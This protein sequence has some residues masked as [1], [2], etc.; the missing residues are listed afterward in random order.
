MS[1]NNLLNSNQ[2]NSETKE[3]AKLLSPKK[4]V[5]FQVLFGEVGSENITRNFL[6]DVLN[7]KITKIDL[8]KNPILRRMKPTNKMGIL[9]VYAEING[10]EKCNIE[11]QIGKRDNIIQRVLYYWARTYERG[12]KIKED[13]NQLSRTIV[14]LITDFK[15]NGLE[16]LSYFTKWKLMEIEGGKRILTD[17]MEVDIIEIPKIYELKETDKYN[18]AIEWLYFLENPESERVKSIMKENEGIQ[19]AREKL[20]EI[21]NDEIMQRLADWQESAEHEEAEVRNMGY[22]EGKEAGIQEGMRQGREAGIEEGVKTG[23][24]Q[25][26]IEI[27]KKMKEKNI[28]ISIIAEVTGLTEKQIKSIK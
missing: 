24:K 25:S 18:K 23:I 17:Y 16:E 9:D 10:N 14:I 8:S 4:D 21:S 19:E 2:E 28:D 1:E 3:K 15:I 13:Y 7:E 6:Q 26:K 22:R 20:E 12:L 11:L 5:V 27:A